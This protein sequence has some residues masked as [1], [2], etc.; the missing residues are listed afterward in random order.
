MKSACLFF[1]RTGSDQPL[2]SMVWQ[3]SADRYP[4]ASDPAYQ[5]Q[6][7]GEPF[8]IRPSDRMK[9]DRFPL[10][11]SWRTAGLCSYPLC[12]VKQTWTCYL[13][14]SGDQRGD[15]LSRSTLCVKPALGL[16]A[17]EGMLTLQLF[18]FEPWK[19]ISCLKLICR[20]YSESVFKDK[21]LFLQS[22]NK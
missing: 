4:V 1:R 21:P 17:S 2:L 8:S 19:Y 15:A 11:I 10:T 5:K 3:M 22:R 18:S 6:M 16:I 14:L 20:F 7:M 12:I 13:L 9:M